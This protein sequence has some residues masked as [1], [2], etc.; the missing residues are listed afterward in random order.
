MDWPLNIQE[1]G[2]YRFLSPAN[3]HFPGGGPTSVCTPP[4]AVDATVEL[5][6]DR[7]SSCVTELENTGWLEHFW[8]NKLS[9][10]PES[11]TKDEG[12]GQ[13]IAFQNYLLNL[14]HCVHTVVF[15]FKQD[16]GK[17]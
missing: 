1:M 9:P 8:A 11:T 14:G 4:G 17:F 2:L 10:F 16:P 15:P 13:D 5:H 6:P 3:C 12:Q 7:G